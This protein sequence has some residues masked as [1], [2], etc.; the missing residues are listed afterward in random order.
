MARGSSGCEMNAHAEKAAHYRQRAV[1][2]RELASR[3]KS[4]THREMLLKIADDYERLARIQ[5]QL[6][7]DEPD[8]A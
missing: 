2:M 1:E 4:E 7:A 5:D 3:M 8:D 6:A